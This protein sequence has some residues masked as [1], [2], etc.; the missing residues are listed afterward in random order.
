MQKFIKYFYYSCNSYFGTFILVCPVHG[1]VVYLF[2]ENF[3][4]LL[5]LFLSLKTQRTSL[6]S[7]LFM[8]EIPTFTVLSQNFEPYFIPNFSVEG[9]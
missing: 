4:C 9:T 2:R 5:C 6:L 7:L 1:N 8:I 3:V